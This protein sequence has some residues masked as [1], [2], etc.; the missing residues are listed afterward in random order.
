MPHLC[1]NIS[2]LQ[3]RDPQPHSLMQVVVENLIIV[4]EEAASAILLLPDYL[5]EE[6]EA[7][8]RSAAPRATSFPAASLLG[9]GSTEL[10]PSPSP[11]DTSQM[12]FHHE[13]DIDE[14]LRRARLVC[15]LH[16]PHCCGGFQIC[17][18]GVLADSGGHGT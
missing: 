3:R 16:N 12:V 8:L 1:V 10:P 14:A 5:L 6:I 7:A 2:S 4:L 9:I 11:L 17:L 13:R 18:A 15:F